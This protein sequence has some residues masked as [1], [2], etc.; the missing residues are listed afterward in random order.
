MDYGSYYA[1]PTTW[2]ANSEGIMGPQSKLN[3]YK[4]YNHT[5]FPHP[6]PPT[7]FNNNL[8]PNTIKGHSNLQN[9]CKPEAYTGYQYQQD[10][11]VTSI[12]NRNN[13]DGPRDPRV[14]RNDMYDNITH[15]ERR[16]KLRTCSN[17]NEK[18]FCHLDSFES[19]STSSDIPIKIKKPYNNAD[20]EV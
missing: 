2:I 5:I 17:T 13:N 1:L 9:S 15:L 19:E 12:S 11:L 7:I 4:N 18:N 8:I 14:N 16:D 20:N 3:F 10:Y 6:N